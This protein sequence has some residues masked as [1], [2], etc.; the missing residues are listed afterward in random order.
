[1]RKI[2]H[3]IGRQP[4]IVTAGPKIVRFDTAL[5]RWT[6][7][8]IALTRM[9]GLSAVLLTTAGRKTGLQRQSPLMA[10]PDG[11]GF[12]LIASNFGRQGHPAWST[13]LIANP[14]ATIATRGH[15]FK[16]K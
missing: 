11:D 5:Q 4:W 10:T 7:G 1:M 14:E 8:R 6:G 15:T 9:A 2:A 12:V 16:V 3:L 13:N